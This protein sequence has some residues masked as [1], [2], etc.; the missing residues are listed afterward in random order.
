MPDASM[1]N[2]MLDDAICILSDKEPPLAHTDRGCHYRW[3]PFSM[4]R[5]QCLTNNSDMYYIIANECSLF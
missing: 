5:L 2:N 1:V 3:C 4:P